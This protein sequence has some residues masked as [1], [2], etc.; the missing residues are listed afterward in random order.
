MKTKIDG[1]TGKLLDEE[2]KEKHQKPKKHSTDKT[3]KKS[4]KQVS[5]STLRAKKEEKVVLYN[6]SKD[7][8]V[9]EDLREESAKQEAPTLVEQVEQT[10]PPVGVDEASAEQKN[11]IV[12]TED[13]L[14][15][16]KSK[17]SKLSSSKSKSEANLKGKQKKLKSKDGHKISAS[18]R[19]LMVVKSNNVAPDVDN[20]QHESP[21]GGKKVAFAPTGED[22]TTIN[23]EA[24]VSTVKFVKKKKSKSKVHIKNEEGHF[25]DVKSSKKKK[26]TTLIVAPVEEGII[27]TGEDITEQKDS[28]FGNK[29]SK[30]RTK[31]HHHHHHSKKGTD[32]AIEDDIKSKKHKK[33]KSKEKKKKI[34]DDDRNTSD[35]LRSSSDELMTMPGL[36]APK[37]SALLVNVDDGGEIVARLPGTNR[38]GITELTIEKTSAL[39]SEEAPIESSTDVG[40]PIINN[41]LRDTTIKAVDDES[42]E[43]TTVEGEFRIK[44]VE[45][46]K[47]VI[48]NGK[49]KVKKEKSHWGTIQ[50]SLNLAQYVDGTQTSS[51][52]KGRDAIRRINAMKSP[53]ISQLTPT[54]NNDNDNINNNKASCE[55][56][57]DALATTEVAPV[58]IGVSKVSTLDETSP[59]NEQ[60]SRVE[61]IPIEVEFNNVEKEESDE[62]DTK[63]NTIDG[64]AKVDNIK[65]LI[66]QSDN[67]EEQDFP[68][69]TTQ[70]EELKPEST[71]VR[72]TF[73]DVEKEEP[74]EED[75]IDGNLLANEKAD[76]AIEIARDVEDTKVEYF[77]IRNELNDAEQEKSDE[78]DATNEHLLADESNDA[79]E[80]ESDEMDTQN[81]KTISDEEEEKEDTIKEASHNI[82]ESKLISTSAVDALNDVEQNES[83]D[84]KNQDLP[85]DGKE[86][87]NDVNIR[88]TTHDVEVSKLTSTPVEDESNYVDQDQSVD[89]SN[90]NPIDY[91]DEVEEDEKKT[92]ITEIDHH[93]EE[94]EPEST[95]AGESN[96]TSMAKNEFNDLVQEVLKND[97]V[98]AAGHVS[99]NDDSPADEEEKD[100]HSIEIAKD[101][102]S[103]KYK[104]ESEVE[105]F[106]SVEDDSNCDGQEDN[107]KKIAENEVEIESIFLE[108]NPSSE[109]EKE[110]IPM[111]TKILDHVPR[112]NEECEVKNETKDNE[113]DVRDC[114]SNI[115]DKNTHRNDTLQNTHKV[116]GIRTISGELEYTV[117]EYK[118]M[119]MEFKKSSM[120]LE[121]E[122][123]KIAVLERKLNEEQEKSSILERQLKHQC[124][125]SFSLNMTLND[126]R[127]NVSTIQENLVDSKQRWLVGKQELHEKNDLYLAE[128]YH[129]INE[130]EENTR[131]QNE[132]RLVERQK[133][134]E[135]NDIKMTEAYKLVE[136]TERNLK[137]KHVQ[138]LFERQELY[139][140]AEHQLVEAYQI[141]CKTE[142]NL[143]E[144]RTK[145]LLER[146]NTYEENGRTLAEAYKIIYDTEMD[147]ESKL[148]KLHDYEV[149]L[150]E[151][152]TLIEHECQKSKTLIRQLELARTVSNG[153]LRN[154]GDELAL[155]KSFSESQVKQIRTIESSIELKLTTDSEIAIEQHQRLVRE[156][157]LTDEIMTRI[158]EKKKLIQEN[159]NMVCVLEKS[160]TMKQE[161]LELQ[162]RKVEALE[163]GRREKEKQLKS[164][165]EVTIKLEKSISKKQALEKEEIM[166]AS[167]LA[168]TRASRKAA[169]DIEED[170]I[171]ELDYTLARKEALIELERMKEKTLEQSIAKKHRLIDSEVERIKELELL[172][173][174]KK[175]LQTS[176]RD[177]V[178]ALKATTTEKDAILASE[179]DVVSELRRTRDEK[180]KI[181]EAK[182]KTE[183]LIQSRI[184][185]NEVLLASKKAAIE[186]VHA[187]EA[188]MNS[189]LEIQE[190][191]AAEVEKQIKRKKALIIKEEY[192]A[193]CLQE[194]I[195]RKKEIM[196]LGPASYFVNATFG[197]K[198]LL[199]E[200]FLASS[201][202]KTQI[203]EQSASVRQRKDNVLARVP[204]IDVCKSLVL[205]GPKL[206]MSSFLRNFSTSLYPTSSK[207]SKI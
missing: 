161:L 10:P 81:K 19:V 35:H 43:S 131:F 156:K 101:E 204:G 90:Q 38:K 136:E 169:I 135:K 24:N 114:D 206:L 201:Y 158:K 2:K 61:G 155:Q 102:Q 88:E 121:K 177:A 40:E 67:E 11:E 108:G 78:E 6:S 192:I 176:E 30:K 188:E 129:I 123:N 70:N 66:P 77:P 72:D 64:E 122:R 7:A 22:R 174:Q 126:E 151:R 76:T 189:E 36:I 111:E 15:K 195:L 147:L 150:E 63:N 104:E 82:E 97:A 138:G 134:Y 1:T 103:P 93:E 141:I 58:E 133:L 202:D 153:K 106:F 115:D 178:Q 118:E 74:D 49:K 57:L 157:S 149:S 168:G 5:R 14:K 21:T 54:N 187:A 132:R 172:I 167:K 145:W 13:K 47:D 140:K 166:I 50:K 186:E 175:L 207:S 79:D 139:D 99:T 107:S 125:K 75:T 51:I 16:K 86:R 162:Q 17:R 84:T 197:M 190:A 59:I 83:C 9:V 124:D 113:K 95:L 69:E 98:Y 56:Q 143:E 28:V 85:D 105:S 165:Q 27:D 119:E 117:K 198:F 8:I 60:E 179:K 164:N 148:S 32:E 68:I 116:E 183:E 159:E 171:K 73:N 96:L 100:V 89:A 142:T 94:S 154:I 23:Y 4:V 112:K 33:K 196:P 193:K 37:I 52:A 205:N 200:T 71:L 46:G 41:L 127:E 137:G 152:Q 128:A 45:E 18:E 31:H 144:E 92:I 34:I 173:A 91:H 130:S 29:K 109:E 203:R 39:L 44:N 163:V 53:P 170:Q 26:L 3:K 55:D 160:N 42:I 185:E 199:K 180:E 110:H 80:E 87:G 146:Q 120:E 182:N 12:D 65:K 20:L 25:A 181:L 48:N 194:L 184:E 62:D 191:A